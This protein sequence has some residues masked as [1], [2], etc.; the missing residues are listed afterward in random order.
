MRTLFPAVWPAMAGLCIAGVYGCTKEAGSTPASPSSFVVA[1]ASDSAGRSAA[2]TDYRT[3]YLGSAVA[4][5]G[6]TG[7]SS[8]CDQGDTPDSVKARELQRLN[9]FRRLCSLPPVT[10]NRD[11]TL[12]AQQAALMMKDNDALDHYPPL[13]WKCFTLD[14][15]LAAANSNL[16]L[17]VSGPDAIDL[18]ISDPGVT[19]LGHR[20][21]ALYP[22]LAEVGTGDTDFTNALWVIGGFGARPS[23]TFTAYPGSGYIPAPLVYSVWSFSV[24]AADFSSASVTVSDSTGFAYPVTLSL[25][26]R[27]YGDNTL[28]WTFQ[29]DFSSLKT[30]LRL[31][32]TVSGVRVDRALHSYKYT[33]YIM[34][35]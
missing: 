27:G 15:Q 33:V 29:Q 1:F 24:S 21:W 2:M 35:V 28:G 34:A 13:T 32:V 18:Y 4:S 22:A 3:N 7:H 9:Y 17:G 6:W 12:K 5:V 31:D 26:D 30:D 8:D 16:T 19:T 25:T 10:L 11:Y 20:R 14:G 23:N